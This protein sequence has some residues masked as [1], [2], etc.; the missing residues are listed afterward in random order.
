MHLHMIY[1]E[2]Y[3]TWFAGGEGKETK[4][5]S[6]L[7]LLFGW[8]PHEVRVEYIHSSSSSSPWLVTLSSTC[9]TLYR[10]TYASY[11]RPS[12]STSMHNRIRH[13]P[14][15]RHRP[16]REDREATYGELVLTDC[17]VYIVLRDDSEKCDP[18]Q[19]LLKDNITRTCHPE[20][21]EDISSNYAQGPSWPCSCDI[22]LQV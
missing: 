12:W 21:V 10:C 15:V 14:T 20:H 4:S 2:R 17:S 22:R 7:F 19:S 5:L 3:T 6:S 18:K 16:V 8:S 1:L 11:W 9:R 13:N